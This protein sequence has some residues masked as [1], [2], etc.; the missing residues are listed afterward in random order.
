MT[1]SI[2]KR[3]LL[4][5]T[6]VVAAF[7]GA[8]GLVLDR[9]Y[10]ASALQAQRER[11]QGDIYTLLAAADVRKGRL[12]LPGGLPDPRFA[13][14]GSG[15]Y[16]VIQNAAGERVWA[17][18]SM[19]GVEL[20]VSGPIPAG[21]TRFIRGEPPGGAMFVLGYGFSW[22]EADGRTTTFTAYVAEDAAAYRQ[23]VQGFRGGLWGWLGAAAGALLLAQGLAISWSLR[24]LRRVARDVRAIEDGELDQLPDLYPREIRGLSDNLNALIR[25]ERARSTRYREALGNLAHSL[26]TPL[27]VL[28]GALDT[29]P[30]DLPEA[31]NQLQRIDNVVDYQLRRAATGGRRPLAAAV[32]IGPVVERLQRT[33]TRAHPEKALEFEIDC[34]ETAL[35]PGS[36]DDLME[37][38]GNLMDN[39]CKWARLWVAVQVKP[40]TTGEPATLRITIS[41]DGPGIPA[42]VGERI[43]GRGI[44]LDEQVPGQGIGLAVVRELVEAYEGRLEIGESE[45]GGAAVTVE[46][47]V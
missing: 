47:L 26:K 23:Q 5:A 45:R 16:A 31:H 33:L 42:D 28:R 34:P 38:L 13:T 6:F 20:P 24:P 39:A 36:T 4:V 9:A 40:N 7:L 22:Q 27:A 11:L 18:G 1:L 2:H 25:A 19:L 3:Q 15:L 21:T 8:T 14:P 30:P 29:N 46:L 12:T 41:D 37:M 44:R 17:S 35:F 32:P 43:T 10:R